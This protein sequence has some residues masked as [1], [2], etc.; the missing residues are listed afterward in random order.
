LIFK[1]KKLDSQK[2]ISIASVSTVASESDEKYNNKSNIENKAPFIL[3][4]E[5]L[6]EI[7]TYDDRACDLAQ[8]NQTWCTIAKTIPTTR[9][10]VPRLP[11]TVHIEIDSHKVTFQRDFFVLSQALWQLPL[12]IHKK[13]IAPH[14][15]LN[16]AGSEETRGEWEVD[17]DTNEVGKTWRSAVKL[18][19]G[20]T[21]FQS[22]PSEAFPHFCEIKD[23]IRR[24]FRGYISQEIL[25]D[26]L[27][28]LVRHSPIIND[29]TYVVV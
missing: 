10:T 16:R 19:D 13:L 25:R 8:V 1:K 27:S 7:M 23:D 3:I 29:N 17:P 6:R 22:K 28:P 14:I 24:T 4:D 15:F 21:E 26:L 2:R 20:Y 11:T 18:S 9:F 12:L 5:V